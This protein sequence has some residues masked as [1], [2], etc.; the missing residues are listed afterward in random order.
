MAGITRIFDIARR[1]LAAQ[2]MGLNVTGHNIANVNTPGYTRQRVMFESTKP[3]WTPD[4]MLGA[5]VAVSNIERVRNG[6]F[7]DRIR[8]EEQALGKWQLK[9]QVFQEIQNVFH[10]PSDAGLSAVLGQFWDGWAALA[11]EPQNGVFRE[12]VRQYGTRLV[13][14][15]HNFESRLRVLQSTLNEELERS[16]EEFNTLLN[17]VASLNDKIS[18]VENMGTT[19]N[20]YRDRRDTLLESLS[21]MADI[22]VVESTNGMTTVTLGGR[23]LVDRS[24]VTGLST[25]S[26]SSG[27]VLTTFPTWEGD[28]TVILVGDGKIKGL[29]VMRDESIEAQ[30]DKLDEMALTL[31]SELNSVHSGGY[32]LNGSTGTNFFDSDTTGAADIA[33]D[34]NILADLAMIAASADGSAGDG[35]I[36]QQIAQVGESQVM[37]GNTVT[38]NDY[39]ASMMGSLGL[40]AQ[41][42]QFM[43][44]N[45]NL[46]VQQLVNQRSSISG[47]SLD[48]VMTN[49]LRFQHAYE[50]AARLV[51]VVDGMMGTLID[52]V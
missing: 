42:A 30:I 3:A 23:V 2:Q 18:A 27:S 19:A 14:T 8:T 28:G 50:A 29:M 13:D 21:T 24:T 26:R 43:S 35:T 10:E 38:I 5:G 4:G 31:V 36:A 25:D 41:E 45:Q 39:F 17:Q 37:S 12:Q 51:S 6:F 47:V 32:G 49:L 20:D 33:L 44:E 46:V 11:N 7:D 1:A 40:A 48:E 9:E 22:R 15:M 16:V 34:A 52:M